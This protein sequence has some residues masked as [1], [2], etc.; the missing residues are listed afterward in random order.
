M[1]NFNNLH[2]LIVNI[3]KTDSDTGMYPYNYNK[4]KVTYLIGNG[5]K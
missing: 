2:L 4:F 5:I 3:F 1:I